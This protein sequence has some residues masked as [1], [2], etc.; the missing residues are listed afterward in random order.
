MSARKRQKQKWD[1]L[2]LMAGLPLEDG[3]AWGSVAEQFQI[4]D[5]ATILESPVHRSFILRGRGMSKTTDIAAIVITLL[6]TEAPSHSQS[7]VYAA[8]AD[9]ADLTMQAI[10]GF[11]QRANLTAQFK[12]GSR[13]ITNRETK[14][15]LSVETSDG[16][17]AY[18]K[19]PWLQIVD[20]LALWPDTPNHR[21]LWAA[22][23]SAVP[24]VPDS[25]LVVIS[26]AGSPT[27]IGARV[28]ADAE[29]SRHWTTSKTPGPSPWW[30]KEDIEATKLALSK[31]QWRRLI[32]CEWAE[33]DDAL[34]TPEDVDAAIRPDASV[35]E[36]QGHRHYVAALDV[37]TRKDMTAL[38]IGHS[39]QRET[40]RVSIIDR[41]LY[42]RPKDHGGRVDLAEVEAAALRECRRY[43]AKLIFDRMQ[44]EQLV[45]NLEREGVRTQEYVFSQAGANRLARTLWG[46]LRDRT[47]E[48]PDEEEIRSQFQTVRLVETGPATVKL[49]NPPGTHDDIPTAVGM[50]LTELT[51]NAPVGRVSISV[52]QGTRQLYRPSPVSALR[53]DHRETRA[54]AMRTM[55]RRT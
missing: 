53:R 54:G 51:A 32:L 31:S 41:V 36:P 24:K 12:L 16:A 28:W 35:L 19:R 40:G 50:L 11:V 27:G 20:E 52:P 2:D 10:V 47:L 13:T 46:A 55:Q 39:E 43:G 30:T 26:T 45:T 17:S 48:L 4:H 22:I 5:A 15:T 44:A 7:Y 29:K 34:T 6:L 23:T 18:G 42:W 33:S 1:I 21:N 49:E 8:D 37:G 38:V 25:R 3:Q 14:A 9:Q